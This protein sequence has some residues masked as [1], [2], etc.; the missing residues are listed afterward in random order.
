MLDHLVY[1]VPDLNAAREELADRLGVRAGEGGKHHGFGTHNALISLG[2]GAYLELIAP[3]P[4]Q[5]PPGRPLPFGLDAL[6]GPRLLTWA[7]T[8]LDIEERVQ[9]ARAAGY[10]PGN[11]IGLS[12][13]QPDGTRLEWRMTLR[14][15][16]PGDGLVPFL[17]DWGATPHPSASSPGGCAL[18]SLRAEHPRPG[19]VRPL[20]RA[21]DVDLTLSEGPAPA[22][23]AQLDPT[24]TMES[25][26]R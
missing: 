11:V 12:R 14:E 16:R 13:D 8:A 21:L 15:E 19:D 23:I 4:E 25:P 7:V 24:L 26:I 18:I 9:R 6:A 2:E 20:L 1:G 10:D 5:A 3:D 22:L 17:I